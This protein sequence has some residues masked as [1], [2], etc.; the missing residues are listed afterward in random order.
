MNIG[1]FNKNI[2]KEYLFMDIVEK[3]FVVLFWVSLAIGAVVAVILIGTVI[4]FI[5]LSG[6][7][8]AIVFSLLGISMASG[9][10]EIVGLLAAIISLFIFLFS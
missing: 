2:K 1:S 10:F 6:I 3:I 8:V 7:V 4:P 5:V 9:L